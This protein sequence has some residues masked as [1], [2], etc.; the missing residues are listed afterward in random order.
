MIEQFLEHATNVWGT[1]ADQLFTN[2]GKFVC[3]EDCQQAWAIGFIAI[4]MVAF[5]FSAAAMIEGQRWTHER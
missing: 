5:A 1:I 4:I 3:Q 2:V